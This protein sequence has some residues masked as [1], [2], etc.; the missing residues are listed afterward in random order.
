MTSQLLTQLLQALSLLSVLL[1]VGTFL[2][3]KVKL[4]QSLY[5]P[6]S[7]IGGF[8][9]MIISPEILGRFSNYSISEEWIKTYS[10]LPGILSV[11]IFAAIP[12]GMFLNENK[13]IKS[14]YPSK[15]LICFG[16]FQCASMSQSAIGYATNMFFNKINPQLNMYRT[17]GY[18]LSA[19]F[20]GGHGLAAATG[21]LLEGFGI[22]QWEI[23]QGVA[24]T[25][26]TIGLIGGI[27][28]GI[29]FINL[30]VRKNKTKIIKRINDNADKSMEVGYN[31]DINKQNSLG[32]ET[33][34]SSSIETITFHLAIIFTVCGIAYIV[35]NFVKKM[36]IAG[37]NVLPV[38]TYSMIIMFA[39][40]FIIKKLNLVWMV[41]AKVKAKIMG[42][43]SDFAIV[44]A[45]TSL[46]IKAIIN[47]IAPITVMCILGFIITYLLVFPLN[48][49]FFKEDYSFERAIISWGTLT[50]VLIT[51]MTLL[52]ICDPEY[53]SPALSEFS[54]GFSLMSV[55]GLLIVPI[56]NTVLAVGSTFDNFITAIISAILYFAFAF[57]IFSFRKKSNN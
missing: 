41:D 1:L 45:M 57:M 12:L 6:A 40:N 11:P 4:F 46:P 26:A 16:L 10:L 53:K 35:L 44:S 13:N 52:K 34:L 51:G 33:F 5:L 14:M 29:I 2:R 37:L 20:A 39:L 19:G 56:L 3:A 36:N 48:S 32:R 43:L 24:L 25:T 28:F 21:K 8:I 17:F 30:A 49:F 54:L 22:P 38:W 31:K 47:Y 27:V 42:T 9:G 50:G 55:T 18:E 23:A 7:V 15:V